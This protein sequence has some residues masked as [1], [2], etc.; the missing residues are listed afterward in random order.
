DNVCSGVDIA[1][2]GTTLTANFSTV[3]NK[4]KI[5]VF[6]DGDTDG[7]EIILEK[8]GKVTLCELDAGIHTVRMLKASSPLY[9]SIILPV[10]EAFETDGEFLKAPAKSDL[11]IEFIGDSITAG[12]GS[13][14]NATQAGQTVENS[15]PTKAY[16]YLT[17]QAL[18]ADFAIQALEGVCAKDGSPNAYNTYKQYGYGMSTSYDPAKFDADIVVIGLGENDM[19]HATSD[20]FPYTVEAFRTDYA[21]LIRLVR[22]SHPTAAIVCAFGMMPASSTKQA[23]ETIRAAVADTEDDNIYCV[24]ML[25]NETGGAYHPNATSHKKNAETLTALIR[26]ILAK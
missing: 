14:G 18:N 19:W 23:E 20:L 2:I 5:R 26:E 25:S 6:V 11:K 10:G 3:P 16:A 12:C 4:T 1:F 13:L 15:D 22:E 9:N 24:K 7:K 8:K 17:A 21:D